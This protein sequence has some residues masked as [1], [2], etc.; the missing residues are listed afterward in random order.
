MKRD[1]IEKEKAKEERNT[2]KAVVVIMDTRKAEKRGSDKMVNQ[3][4]QKANSQTF[5]TPNF[6]Y[7]EF[8]VV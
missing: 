1:W 8:I 5:C 2:E 3:Q 4:Q 7:D 6:H